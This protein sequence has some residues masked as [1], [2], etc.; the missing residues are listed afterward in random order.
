MIVM[1]HLLINERQELKDRN[2]LNKQYQS[3]KLDAIN[4]NPNI[5]I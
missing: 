2:I 3:E 1:W 4:D 5:K